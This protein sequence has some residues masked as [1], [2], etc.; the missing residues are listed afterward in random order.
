MPL[1]NG[2]LTISAF[3]LVLLPALWLMS[4]F[5]YA[6]IRRGNDCGRKM[7]HT[8]ICFDLLGA[9]F[10]IAFVLRTPNVCVEG[11]R[12]SLFT[13][14]AEPM[15]YALVLP[16]ERKPTSP[17]GKVLERNIEQDETMIL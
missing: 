2:R 6:R 10:I 13:R 15:V 14:Q 7:V 5:H 8:G 3:P 4:V 9:I 16:R 11:L 1:Q 12:P 17:S